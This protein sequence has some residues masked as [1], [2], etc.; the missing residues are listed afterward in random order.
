MLKADRAL[1]GRRF[2]AVF[3]A[4]AALVVQYSIQRVKQGFVRERRVKPY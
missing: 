3:A 1:H 2:A 4:D